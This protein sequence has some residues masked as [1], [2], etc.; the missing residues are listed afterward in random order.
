MRIAMISEHA[1]PLALLGGVDAGGQNQ[2]VAEL[3]TAL[4]RDGHEVRVY[5]RRDDPRL[6]A[7]VPLRPG[8][9][10]EHVPAG[11]A[12]PVP[13]DEL[14]P[15]L[16]IFGE[17]LLGRWQ[18]GPWTPDVV[19]AH[20]WMSG[21]AALTARSRYPVPVVVTYHALGMV[22]RRHQRSADTSPRQRIGYERVLGRQ[23]DAVVAQCSDELGEMI[24]LGVPRERIAL[25]PSGVDPAHFTPHGPAARRTSAPRIL[26]VGRLV[27]RKGYADVIRALPALPGAECVIV[28]GPPAAVL[29]SDPV[30]GNLRTL[31]GALGVADRVRLV[32]GVPRQELP[33]WY[34]SADVLACAP[35]YEPFGLT[36]LEAMAC[37]IPVV[38]YALGGFTDTVVEG[39]TGHLVRPRDHGALATSLRRLLREPSRRMAYGTAA[40][41]RTR[42]CYSWRRTA[43]QLTRLY[44][45]LAA[46][47]VDEVLAAVHDIG[48]PASGAWIDAAVP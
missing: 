20:F 31:A 41:D 47:S 16:G 38:A 34:R 40:V 26:C 32:G 15:Y 18:D 4:A 35:W 23:A 37:G 36:P 25:V 8:V 2:H 6:A 39:V 42:S 19:H 44:A 33:S 14:L 43:E 24:A 45:R 1:S 7:E 46:I 10:V 27:E 9:T 28:G 21:L 48:A 11:P 5:T 29:D 22:K 13:K 3:S 17:W 30:A 12:A